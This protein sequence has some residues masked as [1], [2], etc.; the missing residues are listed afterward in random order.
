MQNGRTELMHEVLDM[1]ITD[2]TDP[3]PSSTT[4]SIYGLSLPPCPVTR[5]RFTTFPEIRPHGIWL[6]P[7]ICLTITTT[8]A[9]TTHDSTGKVDLRMKTYPLVT[10]MA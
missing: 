1:A 8:E 10:R 4:A 2:A 7:R 5:D 6:R 9:K 3:A